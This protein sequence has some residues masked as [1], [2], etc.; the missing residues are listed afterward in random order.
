MLVEEKVKLDN[1]LRSAKQPVPDLSTDHEKADDECM[2]MMLWCWGP[3]IQCICLSHFLLR[4]IY[5]SLALESTGNPT[6]SS[7]CLT[8][9]KQQE[10]SSL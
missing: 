8:I 2:L 3:C 7:Q 10:R 9:S 4:G 6:P 5:F 1:F